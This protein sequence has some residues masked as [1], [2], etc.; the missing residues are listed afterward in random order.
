MFADALAV[1]GAQKQWPGSSRPTSFGR[2]VHSPSPYSFEVSGLRGRDVTLDQIPSV[3]HPLA[4][5]ISSLNHAPRDS[6]SLVR[7]LESPE[8]SLGD[9][10]RNTPRKT[11]GDS[12]RDSLRDSLGEGHV[13]HEAQQRLGDVRK[14]PVLLA[15][16]ISSTP[17]RHDSAGQGVSTGSL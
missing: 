5:M 1:R 7:C 4:E 8:D 16:P 15:T 11:P 10:L 6:F 17:Q 3:A 12:L 9:L 13:V 2:V 14:D